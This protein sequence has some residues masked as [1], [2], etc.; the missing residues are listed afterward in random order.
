MRV[1]TKEFHAQ[2]L[3]CGNEFQLVDEQQQ[4]ATG[5]TSTK[6]NTVSTVDSG[7]RQEEL[8]LDFQMSRDPLEPE[9]VSPAAQWDAP[10][11]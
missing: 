2:C 5:H 11:S 9:D 3:L 10:V 1:G 7:W 8:D 6:T 4:A